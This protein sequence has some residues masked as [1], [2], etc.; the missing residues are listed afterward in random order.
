[1]EFLALLGP[2]SSEAVLLA[3]GQIAL[4][5]MLISQHQLD[6]GLFQDRFQLIRQL[7]GEAIIEK[8][9]LS[10]N[11]SDLRLGMLRAD[12]LERPR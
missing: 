4:R 2:N 12:F 11:E 5:D 9:R 6:V 8:P 3:C 10:V 1:M 7:F